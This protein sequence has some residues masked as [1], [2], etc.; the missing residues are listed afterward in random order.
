MHMYKIEVFV[1]L[2]KRKIFFLGWGELSLF[3]HKLDSPYTFFYRYSLNSPRDR[4]TRV[5]PGKFITRVFSL[6]K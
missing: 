4:Q 3:H 1:N 2:N 6:S 5:A